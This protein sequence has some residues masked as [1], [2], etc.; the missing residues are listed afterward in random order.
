MSRTSRTVL[1]PPGSVRWG[2]FTMI[3]MLTTVAVLVIVLGLMVSLARYVRDQSADALTA[4]LLRQLDIALTRYVDHNGGQL[5]PVEQ[6]LVSGA[7]HL[8]DEAELHRIARRNNEQFVHYLRPYFD[9]NAPLPQGKHSATQPA[10][11]E[12]DLGVLPVSIYDDVTLRDAWGDPI[13]FMQ[14][15]HPA[16]GMAT[17]DHP[18]FFFSAGPDQKYLTREDNLYS[19]EAAR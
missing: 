10:R 5:P 14:R 17:R 16:I 7:A 13:V 18:S 2:G 1:R 9:I 19:Y 15:D 8:P 6:I 4:N 3:E 12:S 11:F